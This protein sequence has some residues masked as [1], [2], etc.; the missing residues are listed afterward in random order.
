MVPSVPS[1]RIS[2]SLKSICTFSACVGKKPAG[3][4]PVSCREGPVIRA[5]PGNRRNT[6]WKLAVGPS[7]ASQVSAGLRCHMINPEVPR[8]SEYSRF[9]LCLLHQALAKTCKTKRNETCI[10]DSPA[11]S[12]RQ[13]CGGRGSTT[14]YAPDTRPIGQGRK[15]CM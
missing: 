14:K 4:G 6:A 7:E 13:N 2:E 3:F 15:R 11:V 10:L 9:S 1:R 12:A 8:Q 5:G